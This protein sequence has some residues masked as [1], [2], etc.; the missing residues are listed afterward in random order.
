[1]AGEEGRD[2]AGTFVIFQGAR[3]V[4]QSAARLHELRS[5]I[6]HLA[7]GLRERR[8]VLGALEIENIGMAAD[9]PGCRAG[10]VQQHGVK[11]PARR[12]SV[13]IADDCFNWQ[14]QARE[15]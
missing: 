3:A 4:D 10:G 7:L 11:E 14:L 6:Q 13:D 12:P 1:M 8:Y 5:R 2:L 15:I 9:S